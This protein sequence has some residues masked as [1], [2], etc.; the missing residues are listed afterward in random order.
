MY[1]FPKNIKI[2]CLNLFLWQNIF[3]S[4]WKKSAYIYLYVFNLALHILS[5]QVS[6]HTFPKLLNIE[7]IWPKIENMAKPP[8]IFL[9][10]NMHPVIQIFS[11]V[12]PW[13][14]VENWLTIWY[15]IWLNINFKKMCLNVPWSYQQHGSL[16]GFK[17]KFSKFCPKL[18]SCNGSNVDFLWLEWNNTY[19]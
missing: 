16:C 7:N 19:R 1:N 3:H 8:K 6:K 4:G 18:K 2:T 17:L 13:D 14:L 10:L 11:V 5:K 15:G 9:A 12:H